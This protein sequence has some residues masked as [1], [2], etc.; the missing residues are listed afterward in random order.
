MHCIF[1]CQWNKS[2]ALLPSKIICKLLL[3]ITL[4]ECPNAATICITI[5]F[6]IETLFVV[7][8]FILHNGFMKH[9]NRNTPRKDAEISSERTKCL[10]RLRQLANSEKA[11]FPVTLNEFEGCNSLHYRGH[12]N[13][14]VWLAVHGI[15]TPI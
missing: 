9:K 14:K 2:N 8:L 11:R 15:F 13:P 12:M 6:S 10:K 5:N 1:E 7:L 4:Y 3:S